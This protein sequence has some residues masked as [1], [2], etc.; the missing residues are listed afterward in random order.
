[1]SKSDHEDDWI[2]EVQHREGFV[3][4]QSISMLEIPDCETTYRRAKVETQFMTSCFDSQTENDCAPPPLGKMMFTTNPVTPQDLEDGSSTVVGLD[5]TRN[6]SKE[7]DLD[8]DIIERPEPLKTGGEVPDAQ[9]MGY[10][11]VN[12]MFESY[13]P[14]LVVLRCL[15]RAMSTQ[16]IEFSIDRDWAIYAYALIAAE[17]IFFSVQLHRLA[18]S[19]PTV[20]VDFNLR[21]GDEL[22]F[23]GMTNSIRKECRAV[24]K[25]MIGL[26]ELS[27][28]IMEDWS[29]PGELFPGS[30]S[31]NSQELS[32]LLQEINSESP[33]LTRYEVAKRLKELCQY[34]SN[35]RAF[36]DLLKEQFVT[37]LQSMLQ[38]GNEDV[39]RYAIYI[40]LNFADDISTL[41]GLELPRL[42]ETLRDILT[43]SQKK[44]T[45]KLA[46][47]LY[48][49]INTVC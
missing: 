42:P 19:K 7:F 34:D 49:A 38:D 45:K 33:P 41:N 2:D 18:R 28:D 43:L 24:D 31:V 14:P 47:D 32:M 27:F 11:L 35:R 17:E 10:H 44:S 13:E 8:A 46:G 6:E 23:L 4:D 26:P 37:G 20:R 16:D 39:V 22:K 25:D 36:T 5:P 1:M 29:T 9:E 40:I 12:P 48:K 21:S 3:L 15:H 30:L